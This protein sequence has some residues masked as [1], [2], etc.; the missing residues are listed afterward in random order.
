MITGIDI[1]AASWVLQSHVGYGAVTGCV[2]TFCLAHSL[3]QHGMLT[4]A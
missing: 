3:P 2:L 4:H 1:L